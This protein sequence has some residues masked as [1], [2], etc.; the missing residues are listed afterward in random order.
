MLLSDYRRRYVDTIDVAPSNFSITERYSYIAPFDGVA[1]LNRTGRRVFV[2]DVLRRLSRRPTRTPCCLRIS[3]FL[4]AQPRQ[5]VKFCINLRA[6]PRG[7]R[8]RKS[9]NCL[10]HHPALSSLPV[11]LSHTFVTPFNGELANAF[12]GGLFIPS[13]GIRRIQKPGITASS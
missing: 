5:R 7:L 8:S 13:C 12:G 10:L 3:E 6:R 11:A 1:A 9:A 2:F 4:S